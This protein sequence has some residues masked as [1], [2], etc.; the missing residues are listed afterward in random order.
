M[1]KIGKL[2]FILFQLLMHIFNFRIFFSFLF[3]FIVLLA[4]FSSRFD[5]QEL[6]WS[7]QFFAYYFLIAFL[8]LVF[9]SLYPN[10]F[11]LRNRDYIEEEWRKVW[12]KQ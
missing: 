3:I 2:F 7:T 10:I 9:V 4:F 11:A 5:E 8:R 1:K 12:R 6:Y